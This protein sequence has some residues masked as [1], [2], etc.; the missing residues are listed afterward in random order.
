MGEATI[1]K[2]CG[3]RKNSIKIDQ[4]RNMVGSWES[5]E[6]F[7]IGMERGVWDATRTEFK[8]HIPLDHRSRGIEEEGDET[9]VVVEISIRN[10]KDSGMK[11]IGSD[12][13]KK[14]KSPKRYQGKGRGEVEI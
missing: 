3:E 8:I 10:N 2:W 7:Q 13:L 6:E 1:A 14:K 12:S 4:S 11:R 9:D 5:K